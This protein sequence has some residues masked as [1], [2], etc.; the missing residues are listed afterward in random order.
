MWE[1]EWF[2]MI[3]FEAGAAAGDSEFIIRISLCLLLVESSLLVSSCIGTLEEGG[4][5]QN[6]A[7]A[8]AA[9]AAAA[10]AGNGGGLLVEKGIGLSHADP[11]AL[12]GVIMVSLLL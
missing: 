5:F 10:A 2:M 8:V 6:H 9:A 11:P 12:I 7:I 1:V 4:S 3:S